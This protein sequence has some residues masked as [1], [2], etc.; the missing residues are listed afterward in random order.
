MVV[1]VWYRMFENIHLVLKELLPYEQCATSLPNLV[2]RNAVFP[3]YKP[4]DAFIL[5][6][7]EKQTIEGKEVQHLMQLSWKQFLF[8]VLLRLHTNTGN[9]F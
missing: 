1:L 3:L 9:I 2:C 6:L 7:E 5:R 4:R 8:F